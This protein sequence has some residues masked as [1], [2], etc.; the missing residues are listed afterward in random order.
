MFLLT[1]VALTLLGALV[2]GSV[3]RYASPVPL[4]VLH[5]LAE[6]RVTL[7]TQG[8]IDSSKNHLLTPSHLKASTTSL[9]AFAVTKN[10][11]TPPTPRM[12]QYQLFSAGSWVKECVIAPRPHPYDPF[13]RAYPVLCP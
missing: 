6:R 13:P 5:P 10:L 8:L 1:F 9:K 2:S 3:S 4:S 12:I 7:F 11:G